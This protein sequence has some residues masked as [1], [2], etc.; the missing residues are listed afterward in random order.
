[1]QIYN[2][3][4]FVYLYKYNDQELI[5]R[6]IFGIFSIVTRGMI[7]LHLCSQ[8][9]VL[10]TFNCLPILIYYRLGHNILKIDKYVAC[11]RYSL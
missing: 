9:A 10:Y 11:S 6:S 8:L 7:V 3:K 1:M 5:N 2:V 4:I